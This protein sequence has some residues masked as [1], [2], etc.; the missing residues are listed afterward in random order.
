MS[1]FNSRNTKTF[2][3]F[4]KGWEN[5]LVPVRLRL[6]ICCQCLWRGLGCP[7]PWWELWGALETPLSA[8]LFALVLQQDKSMRKMKLFPVY[9][10]SG[11]RRGRIYK[12]MFAAKIC[13][14]GLANKFKK[15][16]ADR[17]SN[18]GLC[19][20]DCFLMEA[21]G[22]RLLEVYSVSGYPIGWLS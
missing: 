12:Q 3:C 5:K 16:K 20:Y 22:H 15:K 1:Q 10:K 19:F 6:F 18:F 21:V 13:I 2:P 9:R 14:I 7:F 17:C 8:V 11:W 4:N